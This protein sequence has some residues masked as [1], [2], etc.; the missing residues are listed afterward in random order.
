MG[1]S[2]ASGGVVIVQIERLDGWVVRNVDGDR[3]SLLGASD[4][5]IIGD[6]LDVA[7]LFAE[8]FD[9]HWLRI[10]RFCVARAG[11]AGEDIAAEVFRIAFTD[12]SRFDQSSASARP[13]LFGIA[14]NLI[15]RHYRSAERQSRAVLRLGQLEVPAN[16][17]LDGVD[18]RL[19]AADAAPAVLRQL[20]GLREADREIVLLY[21]WA[22]LSYAEIAEAVGVPVGTVRSRLSRARQKLRASTGGT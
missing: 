20:D 16:E 4:A 9:R 3:G 1:S 17:A 19:D 18:V 6:S 7:E 14:A 15:R 8:I 13:W 5:E 21:A 2:R 11:D 10:H 12:R 22:D